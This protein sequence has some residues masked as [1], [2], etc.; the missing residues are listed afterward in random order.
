MN[1]AI[2][3]FALIQLLWPFNLSQ[4]RQNSLK[5]YQKKKVSN[6]LAMYFAIV[7]QNTKCLD[8]RTF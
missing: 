7:S 8:L 3:P 5:I 6:K 2:W 1:K 4:I